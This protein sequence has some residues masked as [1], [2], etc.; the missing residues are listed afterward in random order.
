MSIA[1]APDACIALTA[2]NERQ[3]TNEPWT[4]AL[5]LQAPA[6]IVAVLLQATASPSVLP[7]NY[8]HTHKWSTDTVSID[9]SSDDPWGCFCVQRLLLCRLSSSPDQAMCIAGDPR[10]CRSGAGS[11]TGEAASFASEVAKAAASGTASPRCFFP[12]LLHPGRIQVNKKS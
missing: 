4:L 5:S 3:S 10:D 7:V 6:T 8:K 11:D 1:T 12:H 2:M 9:P